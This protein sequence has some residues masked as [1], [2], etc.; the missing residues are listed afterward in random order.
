MGSD[1]LGLFL[2][3]SLDAYISTALTLCSTEVLRC[4]AGS[5]AGRVKRD[6]WKNEIPFKCIYQPIMPR[7]TVIQ[8]NGNKAALLIKIWLWIWSEFSNPSVGGA[9]N[10][11]EFSC[12]VLVWWFFFFYWVSVNVCHRELGTGPILLGWE[13]QQQPKI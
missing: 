9:Y 13:R 8:R 6:I 2:P 1:C 7:L 11:T 4:R 12:L 5:R 3:S 10:A